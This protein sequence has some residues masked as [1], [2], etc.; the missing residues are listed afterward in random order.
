KRPQA[1][2]LRDLMLSA[3]KETLAKYFWEEQGQPF[4]LS[5]VYREENKDFKWQF[6]AIVNEEAIELFHQTGADSLF[7]F[8]IMTK[9]IWHQLEASM[10]EMRN[11]FTNV[12]TLQKLQ[13]ESESRLVEQTFDYIPVVELRESVTKP[14]T[15]SGTLKLVHIT[16]VIQSI[17][18]DKQTGRLRVQRDNAW[19]D[20]YFVKGVPI[21]AKGSRGMGEDCF[22]QSMCW[23]EGDFQFES[24]LKTDERTIETEL[25]VLIL[26]GAL[27]L[28]N[29]EFLKSRGL[30]MDSL[31]RKVNNFLTEREF[32]EAL[33][34]EKIYN[35]ELVKKLYLT[36]D[37]SRTV[38]QI[39]NKFNLARSQ[40]VLILSSLIRAELVIICS[41]ATSSQPLS[42]E[43]KPIE[44]DL[45]DF[46][47]L[48][49]Q[50]DTGLFQYQALLVLLE[51]DEKFG[52]K[53]LSLAIVDLQ[54]GSRQ[55]AIRSVKELCDIF[56][57]AP[58]FTGL[59]THYDGD[60]LAVVM[61]GTDAVKAADLL[62]R[63]YCTIINPSEAVPKT[64]LDGRPIPPPVSIGIASLPEDADNIACLLAAAELAVHSAMKHH[65]RVALAREV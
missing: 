57:L 6:F 13:E 22:L 20:I 9:M 19:A 11:T 30:K 58:D 18:S 38:D 25:N 17:A 49:S 7:I 56:E 32:D 16:N 5:V 63:V 15:F 28:D 37:G 23:K 44:R 3:R 33:A 62:T 59:I 12:P 27:L 47:R 14:E 48:L 43:P 1:E 35:I 51:H 46:K 8:S 2:D 60:R 26:Q 31:I 34:K 36:I 55:L 50:R 52:Q 40:W 41:P 65:S 42:I 54:L 21:H 39:V 10:K 64:A 61:P 4:L 24:H 53:P 29:T 45:Y